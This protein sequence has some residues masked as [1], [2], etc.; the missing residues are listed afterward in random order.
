MSTSIYLELPWKGKGPMIGDIVGFVAVTL[1][2]I[3]IDSYIL[4][5]QQNALR[6][7]FSIGIDY[8]ILFIYL[9][10]RNI[11]MAGGHT[12]HSYSNHQK[13]TYAVPPRDYSKSAGNYNSPI[14]PT[15][16]SSTYS[17]SRR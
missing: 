10:I 16:H 3:S 13:P 12:T 2:L 5:E 17:S 14:Y 4:C 9:A 7:V 6:I 11:A 15:H 1:L 8:F